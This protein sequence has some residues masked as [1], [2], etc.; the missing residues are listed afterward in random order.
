MTETTGE[1]SHTSIRHE[2]DVDAPIDRAFQV[3]T[4]RFDAIKPRDHNLMSAAIGETV[5]EPWEG[6]RLYD[7]GVDGT[8]C[9]WGRVLAIDPPHRLRFSWDITPTWQVET[10]PARSSEVEVT[11]AELSESTTR[12]V[13]E[14]RHLDRHGD[15][16]E[17]ERDA[18]DGEHGWPLYL[19][20]FRSLP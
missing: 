18:V 8:T 15:G 19:D 7:R 3:F 20:R 12:V 5:L 16:W 10:D 17:A 6:G 4:Q 9:T 2:I 1:R 13:L 11:F 14:H